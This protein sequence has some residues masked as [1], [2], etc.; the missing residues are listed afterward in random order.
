[1]RMRVHRNLNSIRDPRIKPWSFYSKDKIHAQSAVS[2]ILKD[3]TIKQGSGE[4]FIACVER[5]EKRK[6][7]AWFWGECVELNPTGILSEIPPTATRIFFN[8][9]DRR[10]LYFHTSDGTRVDHMSRVWLTA[11]GECWALGTR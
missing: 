1:M 4:G 6:V 7:F 9:K 3:A 5:G 11:E 10:D 2:V 8:P